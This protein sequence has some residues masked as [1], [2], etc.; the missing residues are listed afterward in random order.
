[1]AQRAGRIHRI[2]SENEVV[3]IIDLISNDTIDEQIQETQRKKE[4]LGEGLIE[5]D[6]DEKKAMLDLIEEI[7][8]K[9]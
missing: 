4:A 6:I 2:G 9:S 8:N 1:M 3:N 5:K 7:K